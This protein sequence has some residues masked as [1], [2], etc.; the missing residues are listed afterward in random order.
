MV[1]L[2]AHGSTI[3][4]AMLTC[5]GCGKRRTRLRALLAAPLLSSLALAAVPGKETA[6]RAR[7]TQ[8]LHLSSPLPELAA[9]NH[10]RFEPEPGVIAERVSY[11]THYG[12]R[13]PAIVYRPQ[14]SS[15]R[16]PAIIVVNGHG[17]DKYT[18]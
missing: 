12:M 18:W 13:V 4:S 15:G 5:L 14:K 17:G 10:G 16:I 11:A 8:A 9:E 7:I 3:P 2:N 1:E 6:W